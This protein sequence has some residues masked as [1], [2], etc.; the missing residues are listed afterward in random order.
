MTSRFE[1]VPNVKYCRCWLKLTVVARFAI[2]GVILSLP[3]VVQAAEQ[4]PR[5]DPSS[6]MVEVRTHLSPRWFTTLSSEMDGKIE[7][8]TVREGDRITQ[9]QV[10]V[11][12]NCGVENAKAKK[13]RT[14]FVQTSK[15]ATAYERLFVLKAK[16]ELEVA[17][18]KA[19][20][21]AASAESAVMIE[22]LKRCVITAPFR[23]ACSNCM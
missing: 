16:S 21:A 12:F 10:L 1:T 6:N 3:G 13:A 19:N 8:L 22:I 20:A 2:L 14:I 5:R 15:V 23:A 9:G 4:N 7:M 17:E 18:A 11:K